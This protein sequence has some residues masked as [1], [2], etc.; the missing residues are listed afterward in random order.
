LSERRSCCQTEHTRERNKAH[1]PCSAKYWTAWDG[2]T[3]DDLPCK[4][5]SGTGEQRKTV[6]VTGGA[7]CEDSIKS[8]AS[9]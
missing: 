2:V 9:N 4:R 5:S 1:C 6:P 3:R 8:H 7:P